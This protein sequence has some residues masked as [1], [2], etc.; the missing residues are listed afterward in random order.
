MVL[1]LQ[2]FYLWNRLDVL[3]MWHVA[4]C[5]AY[6]VTWHHRG[7]V[8]WHQWV[9]CVLWGH[10]TMLNTMY[11][12]SC[13]VMWYLPNVSPSSSTGVIPKPRNW[14]SKDLF[15]LQST[16]HNKCFTT[17]QTQLI[18]CLWSSTLYFPQDRLNFVKV[19]LYTPMDTYS[20]QVVWLARPPSLPR[21]SGAYGTV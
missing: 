19:T 13:E 17:P 12:G 10:V 8:M 2:E 5:V 3:V 15:C 18:H 7:Q 4:Q 21:L 6:D 16:Q 20:K 14:F 1:A 11:V 9:L